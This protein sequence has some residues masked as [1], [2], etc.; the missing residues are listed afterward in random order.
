[1]NT[2]C[3]L[4]KLTDVQVVFPPSM[5]GSMVVRITLDTYHKG[6]RKSAFQIA[7]FRENAE[8]ALAGFRLG[9]WALVTGTLTSS[10]KENNGNTYYNISLTGKAIELVDG[11]Y[12]T[13]ITLTEAE[14]ADLNGKKK[15]LMA[16][17]V[18]KAAKAAGH[19]DEEEPEPAPK[20]KK[21]TASRKKKTADTEESKEETENK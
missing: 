16:E 17:M 6:E 12:P 5:S 9:A 11:E 4:G 10:T 18:E 19:L 21:K 14:S 15:K 13:I 1:M 3:I 2:F 7:L 20:P 8:K